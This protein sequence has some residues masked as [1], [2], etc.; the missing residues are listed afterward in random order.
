MNERLESIWRSIKV[1]NGTLGSL[2]TT[3][4]HP[5]MHYGCYK[6]CMDMIP[7]QKAHRLMTKSWGKSAYGEVIVPLA[8]SSGLIWCAILG[9]YLQTTGRLRIYRLVFSI[10]Q[11]F[12]FPLWVEK[13]KG[14]ETNRLPSHSSNSFPP[15]QPCA[16]G[17]KVVYFTAHYHI[18]SGQLSTLHDVWC[19][20][21]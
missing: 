10:R 1:A 3:H 17:S 8:K 12:S 4:D 15:V 6:T 13:W 18:L 7:N 20:H 14:Q 21:Q 11:C 2:Q 16:I 19:C 9:L 5:G